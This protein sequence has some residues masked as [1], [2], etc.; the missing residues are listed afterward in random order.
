MKLRINISKDQFVVL[1]SPEDEYD[2]LC[3]SAIHEATKSPTTK[4]IIDTS[5]SGIKDKKPGGPDGL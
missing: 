2:A 4:I 5:N 1:L 3:V